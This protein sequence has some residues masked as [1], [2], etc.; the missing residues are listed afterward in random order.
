M[1]TTQI[2]KAK[3]EF[4]IEQLEQHI[5]H[6]M[7]P[8]YRRHDVMDKIKELKGQ[9][10]SLSIMEDKE[11]TILVQTDKSC[12]MARVSIDG[13]GVMEGNF[14]DFHPGCHGINEYGDFNGFDSL[15]L[16]ILFKLTKEGKKAK[17]IK[18]RYKIDY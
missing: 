7:K 11:I 3:L 5:V 14:W 17:I 6:P 15:A 16:R 1:E 12:E 9:L 13:I 8:G 4:A 10:K 2:E 18:E